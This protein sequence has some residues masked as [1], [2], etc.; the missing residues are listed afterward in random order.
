MYAMQVK[1]MLGI[2]NIIPVFKG[3]AMKVFTVVLITGLLFTSCITTDYPQKSTKKVAS[4]DATSVS[5]YRIPTDYKQIVENPIFY[6]KK[7]DFKNVSFIS[8]KECFHKDTISGPFKL[9]IVKGENSK[10]LR[11]L[12]SYFGSDWIFFENAI[13][14]N[15]E[16]R[17]VSYIF[18][19]YDKTTEVISGNVFERMDYLLATVMTLNEKTYD[20]N[21]ENV[22]QLQELLEGKNI[23]I[24]L[25][26]KYY[27]D[28]TL[29]YIQAKAFVDTIKYYIDL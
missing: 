27:K 26:G 5:Q 16:G 20:L 18:K 17:R 19:S 14:L 1:Q 12:F 13:L 8:H 29:N 21:L 9:Y 11:I 24:R 23:R 3:V 7:D 6:V 25:T 10:A 2:L 4:V 22:Q 15:E 28:Y